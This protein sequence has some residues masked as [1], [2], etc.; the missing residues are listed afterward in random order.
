M[1]VISSVVQIMKSTVLLI[2][3]ETFE[4]VFSCCEFTKIVEKQIDIYQSV[5]NVK[6][7]ANIFL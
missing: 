5:E 2:I 4:F 6:F 3:Y 7:S 1:Y